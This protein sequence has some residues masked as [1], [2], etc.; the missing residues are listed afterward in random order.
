MLDRNYVIG[1]A[2]ELGPE[3]L[4]QGVGTTLKG[5][6]ELGKTHAIQIPQLLQLAGVT[7]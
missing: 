4:G 1:K 2:R 7:R 5:T 6:S 3:I